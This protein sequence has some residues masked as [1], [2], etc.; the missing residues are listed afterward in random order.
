[1][2]PAAPALDFS[3]VAAK[4]WQKEAVWA[5]GREHIDDMRDHC[6]WYPRC[7]HRHD[8]T[9]YCHKTYVRRPLSPPWQIGH[10]FGILGL[11]MMPLM[12]TI[13]CVV[14]RA[15]RTDEGSNPLYNCSQLEPARQWELG[16]EKTD[17]LT[18]PPFTGRMMLGPS[19][20]WGLD[21]CL[22]PTSGRQ[23]AVDRKMAFVDLRR[24]VTPWLSREAR[25][26]PL[27][28]P[29]VQT[30]LLPGGVKPSYAAPHSS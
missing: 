13:A 23:R 10:H 20:S 22:E 27:T 17:D 2:A 7:C 21:R 19:K 5:V 9:A 4:A 1:M 8:L 29:R 12:H 3:R 6:R 28:R 30:V 24:E 11:P 15:L 25:N 18:E 16:S 14:R 26:R